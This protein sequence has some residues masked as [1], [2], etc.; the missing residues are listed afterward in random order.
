[1]RRF[2]VFF[3]SLIACLCLAAGDTDA[4]HKFAGTWEAKVKDK[5]VCTI[6]LR[7]GDS[8]SGETED[9]DINVDADGNLQEPES[10]PDADTPSP[11]LNAKLHESTL[12][13]EVK[14]GDDAV[15]FAMKLVGDG[16]AEL[17]ILDAPVA[18]KP[19]RFLRR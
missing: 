13:F 9:C 11:I 19:I 7:V 2:I 18:L 15:K 6:R 5:V 17:T 4:S 1:M 10:S 8:I 14:E 3:L 12:T 16:Q